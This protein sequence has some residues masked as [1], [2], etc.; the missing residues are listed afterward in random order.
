M[1]TFLYRSV[2]RF[3][4]AEEGQATVLLASMMIMLL[5]MTG[6]TLDVGKA[7]FTYKVLQST[8]DAAALAG[9]SALPASTATTTATKYSAVAGNLNARMNLPGVTMVAGYPKV[10][11]LGTISSDGISCGAPSNGNALQVRQTI[12]IPLTFMRV[13]GISQLTMTASA[14]AAAKGAQ[15]A[16]YNVAIIVD[17]TGSMSGTDSDSQCNDS[18]LNCALA[19][20]QVLL[21]NLSPC[22]P[23]L[24]DCG[25]ASNGVVNKP[26]DRVALYTFPSLYSTTDAQHEYDCGGTAP[27]VNYYTD[28]SLNKYTGPASV[29]KILDYQSD[30]KTSAATTTLNPNSNLVKAVHG[31]PG[32]KG[33]Q[34]I[35]MY[36]YVAGVIYA[37][38][39]DLINLDNSDSTHQGVVVILTDGDMNT[40]AKYMPNADTTSGNYASS[41]KQCA[42]ADGLAAYANYYSV[43]VYAVAYGATDSGCS[44]DTSGQTPCQTVQALASSPDYFYSDYTSTGGSSTCVS[45]SHPSNN[46]KD[47][48][49]QIANSLSTGR[50]I[51]DNTT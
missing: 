23:A 46:L 21:Q 28:G 38:G 7:L 24:S 27:Q 40:P 37:A 47:I 3:F 42:Q 2:C 11:C 16:P 22:S 25:S 51:P 35:N 43:R 36:T 29:Y 20:V 6:L 31:V 8:T 45:S 17:S 19:G 15:R 39:L 13:V 30:Y 26:Y 18:R 32:C 50:L 10:K 48:F 14:T 34:P 44:T 49:K 1:K 4:R 9:A 41:A 12:T 33:M 5:A